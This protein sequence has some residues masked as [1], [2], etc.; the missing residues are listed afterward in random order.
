MKVR[1]TIIVSGDVQG[2]G[3]RL[4]VHRA[5]SKC[6]LVGQ[7]RNLD[8]G[9]VEVLCEGERGAISKLKRGIWV[10]S[11]PIYVDNLTITYSVPTGEFNRFRIIRPRMSPGELEIVERLDIG[12]MAME[13]LSS[14]QD[15]TT[16]AVKHLG[17][18]QDSTLG[19]IKDLGKKQDSTLGA[20]KDLGKKQDSTLGAIKDLGKKQDS[21]LGAIKDL[22]KKQDS[23]LGAIKDLGKKQ[24]KTLVAVKAMDSHSSGNFKR[25]NSS[26][27]GHFGRL[28]GK[29]GR[30]GKTLKGMAGDMKGIRKDLRKALGP[31]GS[32]DK[33]SKSSKPKRQKNMK[34]ARR[35]PAGKKAQ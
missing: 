13:K 32:R 29:Y 17:K 33:K 2:V 26:I 15:G 9:N 31:F 20:I 21:T 35:K 27:S 28:D 7:V 25:L 23:T 19:A 22:G 10:R 18:K 30:F 4:L 16:G 3:Y 1:A 14:K 6:G 11:G 24:D 5:A 12:L 34:R 8:D